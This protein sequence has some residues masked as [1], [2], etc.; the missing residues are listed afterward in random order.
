MAALSLATAC[1]TS[2]MMLP[3]PMAFTL[4]PCGAREMAMHL[5]CHWQTS[6]RLAPLT[7]KPYGLKPLH[8]HRA[9]ADMH[10]G[11]C[12]R[13][14]DAPQTRPAVIGTCRAC[15]VCNCHSRQSRTALDKNRPDRSAIIVSSWLCVSSTNWT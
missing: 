3:G 5:H 9:S 7:P 6:A 14:S 1:R 11:S 4:M 8:D 12:T 15:Q 2:V 10:R 13:E